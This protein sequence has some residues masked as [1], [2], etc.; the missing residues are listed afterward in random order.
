MNHQAEFDLWTIM[1]ISYTQQCTLFRIIIEK[2]LYTTL[3][4]LK[5]KL[6]VWFFDCE[7]EDLSSRAGAQFYLGKRIDK[8]ER[9]EIG[10][11]AGI[12][13]SQNADNADQKNGFRKFI[14]HTNL[15]VKQIFNYLFFPKFLFMFTF[16]KC[17]DFTPL[18]MKVLLKNW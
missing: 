4:N 13:I 14:K 12:E 9:E 17:F 1:T 7:E 10:T 18:K 6:D 3:R 16:C 8:I 15:C 11:C 2:L 5:E